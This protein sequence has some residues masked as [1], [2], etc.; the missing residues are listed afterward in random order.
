RLIPPAIGYPFCDLI[1]D[2]ISTRRESKVIQAIRVNQW[3]ARGMNLGKEELDQAARETLRHNARSLYDLYH[4]IERPKAVQ[5]MIRLSS[6]ARE[7]LERPEFASRGLVVAGLHLSSF[8]LIL[9]SLCRQGLK[10][11]VLTI[12]EPQGGRRV[13]YEMR[14]RTGMNLLPTSVGALRQAV[15]YLEQGGMVLTGLDRPVPGA[16]FRPK[17]FGH[18]A[19]LPIHYAYLASR[20]CV[21]VMIMAAIQGTDGKY[22][23]MN[24]EPIEMDD[25]A[26]GDKGN[27][28]N[29]EKVL[30]RAED[31]IR[32]A[33][34]QWNVPLPVWPE[35]LG[36]A[37]G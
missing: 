11:L 20:A 32:L 9:Q 8:D 25:H 28:R 26:E 4:Y 22:H 35:L 29:A 30:R 15:K 13:E 3:V 19:P 23:I 5:R 2:W 1:A 33:P 31:F 18:P 21:P 12:P 27:L 16:K 24:S 36:K 10:I 7:L 34:R 6:E 17:F 14:K 37:P